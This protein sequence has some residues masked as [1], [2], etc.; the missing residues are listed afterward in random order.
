[1][2]IEF[3]WRWQINFHFVKIVLI[4]HNKCPQQILHTTQL[5]SPI[6]SNVLEQIR[7]SDKDMANPQASYR[8]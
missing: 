5:I 7:E 3:F 2:Y 4:M 8:V 1:M 6:T